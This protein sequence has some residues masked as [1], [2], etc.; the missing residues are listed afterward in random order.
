MILEN[1]EQELSEQVLTNLIVGLKTVKLLCQ[2]MKIIGTKIIMQKMLL[3][4]WI[5]RL[6]QKVLH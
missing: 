2:K 3:K 6:L 5:T 4:H 1:L